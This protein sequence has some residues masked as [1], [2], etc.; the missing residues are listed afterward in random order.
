MLIFKKEDKVRKL[1]LAHLREV[2]ECLMESRS[3]LE[4]YV[5]GNAGGVEARTSRVIEI[6]SRAD[7]LEREIRESLL[8]GAF[9]PHVRSDVYRLVQAVDAIAGRAEDVAR[10]LLTQ[11]PR[12]P[13]EFEEHL[14]E[15]FRE[16]LDCFLE[17]RKAMKAFFKPKGVIESLHEHVNRVCELETEIDVL[18]S[19]LAM[20]IFG[21]ELELSEKLH[22]QRLV[23]IIADIA[24]LAEDAG[25]ELE[26]AAMKSVV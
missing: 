25:D 13:Q 17:L 12:I 8:D 7:Q 10:F 4:E 22:L 1:V 15:L 24:D 3:T 26:F 19:N 9:L 5:T 14:L 18:E 20:Q 6:E 23:T 11:S 21:S 2:N 16:S